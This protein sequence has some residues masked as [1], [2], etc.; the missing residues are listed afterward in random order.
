M[1]QKQTMIRSNIGNSQ[2]TIACKH[3]LRA[4][5]SAYFFLSIQPAARK[6]ATK[7]PS[8]THLATGPTDEDEPD[9]PV[10]PAIGTSN[11]SRPE[12]RLLFGTPRAKT[13]EEASA[14][15]ERRPSR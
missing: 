15:R 4:P 5:A 8:E 6:P 7:T 11:Q 2:D 3:L 13:A 9:E 14:Y 1:L 10:V 12:S